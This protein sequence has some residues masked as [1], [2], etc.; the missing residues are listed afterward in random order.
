[1]KE[2][3]KVLSSCALVVFLSNNAK[4]QLWS[5]EVLFS[6]SSS[7][8][9]GDATRV[10]YHADNWYTYYMRYND[11]SYFC[12]DIYDALGMPIPGSLKIPMD[13]DFVITDFKIIRS[14]PGFIGSYGG[15]GMYG[16]ANSYNI[17]YNDDFQTT[18]LPVVDC[19]NRI[20]IIRPPA[21]VSPARTKA[22]AIGEK[23]GPGLPQS[24]IL[25]FYPIGDGSTE[26]YR[27]IPMPYDFATGEL[28]VADDVITFGKYVIFATQDTRTNHAPI[29][30]R[31]SDTNNVLFNT[32][33]DSQWQILLPSHD[34]VIGKIRMVP[35]GPRNFVLSYV[36]YDSDDNNYFLCIHKI[37]LPDLISGLNAIVSHEVKIMKDCCN[38]VDVIYE[39]DVNA[40]MILLNGGDRS[41][42]YHAD[43]YSTLST[44]VY[45]LN[46]SNGNLYSIDTAGNYSTWNGDRYI[47]VGDNRFFGQDIS[48][49]YQI[50]NSCYEIIRENSILKDPPRVALLKEQLS[51]YTDTKIF[52]GWQDNDVPFD[53][54]QTC[55]E[56]SVEKSNQ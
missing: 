36:K 37:N 49:G 5:A 38:M 50:E 42:I 23:Y 20:T 9:I 39:P 11:S 2:I 17:V 26:P 4:A 1:M 53:G 52:V 31:I 18:K 12:C 24:F 25:E 16:W 10:G 14:R 43:P 29:N 45:K 27:Y 30:L 51:R 21:G 44:Y 13:Q 46:Y 3:F 28:E 33:I 22:C 54:L 47:A 15:V 6:P 41:E 48:G 34:N 19:L 7:T 8:L 40:M 35:I 55:I 56:S 32:S